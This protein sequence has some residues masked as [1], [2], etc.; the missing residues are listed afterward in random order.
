MTAS[1]F[2][3][4]SGLSVAGF[5]NADA[6][7]HRVRSCAVGAFSAYRRRLLAVLTGYAEVILILD[8]PLLSSG[9]A[10]L[11]APSPLRT[12]LEGFPSSGSSTQKRLHEKRG[13]GLI[14]NESD[15]LD[16]DLL[17]IR[18]AVENQP[19]VCEAAP[20]ACA[21]VICFAS[22]SGS[23]RVLELST[24]RKSAPFPAR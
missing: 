5:Y 8:L 17:P 6:V 18:A 22:F 19:V 14:Q 4:F 11:L 2:R 13:R 10:P 20:T 9:Q 21:V 16:T 23:S 1:T 24:N 3:P 15:L 7:I 12:G